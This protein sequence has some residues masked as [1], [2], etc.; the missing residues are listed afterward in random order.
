MQVDGGATDSQA[1]QV[2]AAVA[3]PSLTEDSSV[4]HISL[5]YTNLQGCGSACLEESLKVLCISCC[6]V[7]HCN[8]LQHSGYCIS[9]SLLQKCPQQQHTL[10]KLLFAYCQCLQKALAAIGATYY[11]GAGSLKGVVSYEGV[12]LPISSTAGQLW[13]TELAALYQTA[14]DAAQE[15]VRR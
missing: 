1:S 4:K 10:A 14:Q 9:Y 8:Q 3:A 13:A 5:D 11:A 15:H 7:Q 2:L 6:I 12:D